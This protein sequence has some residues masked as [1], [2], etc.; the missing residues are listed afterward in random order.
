MGGFCFGMIEIPTSLPYELL[1]VYSV[2]DSAQF[3][4]F[5]GRFLSLI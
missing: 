2:F 5:R 1:V 4:M 3:K